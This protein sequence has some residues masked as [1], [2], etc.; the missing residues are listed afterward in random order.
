MLHLQRLRVN[1]RFAGIRIRICVVVHHAV[2]QS[3]RRLAGI[4]GGTLLCR[5]VLEDA[6]AHGHFRT[7]MCQQ[8]GTVLARCLTGGIAVDDVEPV[9]HQLSPLLHRDAVVQSFFNILGLRVA[10]DDGTVG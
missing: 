3:Q 9:E 7:G 4:D 6:V 1:H 5:V 8:T 2:L 10:V